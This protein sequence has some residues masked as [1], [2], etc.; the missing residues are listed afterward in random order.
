MIIK[1][2]I[3]LGNPILRKKSKLV[4]DIT[5]KHVQKAIKDLID[6]LRYQNLI[7]ISAPQIGENTRII[8]TEIK[9]TLIR[10][11]LKQDGLKVYINPK[12]IWQSKK[13]V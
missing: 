1:D 9:Q 5:S 7:G 12:I 8:V 13:L 11:N 4:K 2:I 10:K 3:Q 6:T